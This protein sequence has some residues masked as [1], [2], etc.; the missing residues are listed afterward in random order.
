[1]ERESEAAVAALAAQCVGAARAL[2]R[3][4]TG[5]GEQAAANAFLLQVERAPQAVRVAMALLRLRGGADGADDE[6]VQFFAAQLLLSK[7]RDGLAQ[8]SCEERLQVFALVA[9]LLGEA[10]AEGTVASRLALLLA[11]LCVRAAGDAPELLSRAVALFGPAP[12]LQFG[13]LKLAVEE[14]E[15]VW[16]DLDVA[17]RADTL[18]VALQLRCFTLDRLRAV[19]AERQRPASPSQETERTVA[20]ALLCLHAWASCTIM[21]TA[22][23]ASESAADAEQRRR[24]QQD[25]QQQQQ[26]QQQQRMEG[27]DDDAGRDAER[28]SGLENAHHVSLAIGLEHL[29]YRAAEHAPSLLDWLCFEWK[30]AEPDSDVAQ[31]CVG[32][33]SD[34]LCAAPHA[35][36]ESIDVYIGEQRE[37]LQQHRGVS[38][39][40]H[41]GLSPSGGKARQ[42]T[43]DYVRGLETLVDTIAQLFDSV[44]AWREGQPPRH[45]FRKQSVTI[46]DSDEE[47]DPMVLRWRGV[48]HCAA[49]LCSSHAHALLLAC[50]P[51]LFPQLAHLLL[52]GVEAPVDATT[53][54]ACFDFWDLAGDT[55]KAAR[56][57]LCELNRPL[58]Q[59]G[60]PLMTGPPILA[61]PGALELLEAL[62][63]ALVAC[64]A[65]CLSAGPADTGAQR[66]RVRAYDSLMNLCSSWP[67]LPP[68][69]AGDS[70]SSPRHARSADS[71][72]RFVMGALYSRLGAALKRLG[73]A[74][75]ASGS[76]GAQEVAAARAY[77]ALLVQAVVDLLMA[78]A[79][80]SELIS[81]LSNAD[82]D[83]EDG[84]EDEEGGECG[85]G[86][87]GGGAADAL[88]DEAEAP[89]GG[90]Y[91][92]L[93]GAARQ[94]AWLW[95]RLLLDLI[96]SSWEIWVAPIRQSVS[97]LISQV[98]PLVVRLTAAL[99]L[100]RA[101]DAAALLRGSL[102][103]PSSTSSAALFAQDD[104]CLPAVVLGLSVSFL[105][106][107]MTLGASCEVAADAFRSV[108]VRVSRE[109]QC[110]EHFRFLP[111]PLPALPE[112]GHADEQGEVAAPRVEA[113]G[114]EPTQRRQDAEK[115]HKQQQLLLNK[116]PPPQQQQQQH[117][118]V[119]DGVGALIDFMLGHPEVGAALSAAPVAAA[120]TLEALA[121][122]VVM[123]TV[124]APG[125]GTPRPAQ[126]SGC[127]CTSGAGN[128][129]SCSMAERVL[130]LR[131]ALDK[132]LA[133]VAQS[134]AQTLARLKADDAAREAR[135]D[136]SGGG[137][138]AGDAMHALFALG[139]KREFVAIGQ[140]GHES[141]V[142]AQCEPEREATARNLRLLISVSHGVNGASASLPARSVQ[143]AA[144][145]A[146]HAP[147]IE[148]MW[149]DIECCVA[150]LVRRGPAE[151]EPLD[152]LCD[153]VGLLSPQCPQL[154]AAASRLALVLAASFR[155]SGAVCCARAL[156]ILLDAV[157]AVGGANTTSAGDAT[158]ASFAPSVSLIAGALAAR[159]VRVEAHQAPPPLTPQSPHQRQQQRTFTVLL[160]EDVAEPDFARTAFGL[161][162][163]L[164][165]HFPWA[166]LEP[167]PSVGAHPHELPVL[168]L[169][170]VQAALTCIQGD[171]GGRKAA[172][173]AGAFLALVA[174]GRVLA[175]PR[176]ASGQHP[177]HPQQQQHS[178][179]AQALRA[180]LA[181]AVEA[182]RPVVLE[183]CL[184][185]IADRAQGG[186]SL[187]GTPGVL[188][189]VLLALLGPA[190]RHRRAA[191]AEDAEGEPGELDE[192]R[193]F[194]ARQELVALLA[195][196]H[197]RFSHV[198]P[199]TREAACCAVLC[200]GATRA[201]L[202]A[203]IADAGLLLGG[204][205]QPRDGVDYTK[206]IA[207]ALRPASYDDERGC[208]VD[209]SESELVVI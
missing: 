8:L 84:L 148:A 18:D 127:G 19:L 111:L 160:G 4:T 37:R 31:T 174:G 192:G 64:T 53:L 200:A 32:V 149:S 43:S 44:K 190:D 105:A 98:A 50:E 1:M 129:C 35:L 81:E 72:V 36:T 196:P 26:Q 87:G 110:F 79:E 76:P 14:L 153:L 140:G 166:L 167:A 170:L 115:Q 89:P 71:S 206:A 58:E 70:S 164:A 117:V 75:G 6:V 67:E 188:V 85:R 183:T 99:P 173:A 143:R 191:R 199:R 139:A 184:A 124:T 10:R 175:G 61:A 209:E 114:R 208:L 146:A 94:L 157:V 108:C 68:Q 21:T 42:I 156:G 195:Q 165:T 46:S 77:G 181:A 7:V 104:S 120:R 38:S 20:S 40:Q 186:T 194:R 83:S 161:M 60:M 142:P 189:D 152:S 182:S 126:P 55:L 133:P 107:S 103:F 109:Q 159:L 13:F 128:M 30:Q 147:V 92:P 3:C 169:A 12:R 2:Y 125:A 178:F 11:S 118:R 144:A 123:A 112:Q 28:D 201:A 106:A 73:G 162:G 62:V 97:R 49:A 91:P 141:S 29:V 207:L 15:L 17:A 163:K 113:Y 130:L 39:S 34:C 138:G 86:G 22:R 136:G 63:E 137:A 25:Q 150:G 93:R 187:R 54:E 121:V 172:V 78:V 57:A 122:L 132:I 202:K 180:R 145:L 82:N 33:L 205:M 177:Q 96:S 16:R 131:S 100:N 59:L 176:A 179:G 154:L 45:L 203:G 185:G 204:H 168:L 47:P 41:K 52:Y 134:L 5:P 95:C 66:V 65:H 155:V 74:G 88:Y 48:C 119:M 69:G 24:Q 116:P 80:S 198:P 193:A 51:R 158:P 197:S 90:R 101:A 171:V 9:G 135:M 102:R 151:P 27:R 23:R 56:G